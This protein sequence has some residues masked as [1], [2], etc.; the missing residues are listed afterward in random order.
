MNNTTLTKLQFEELK[1]IVKDFC[2]SNLGKNM[3]QKLLPSSNI[4][5]VK[6]RLLETSE[7]K[8]LLESSTVPLQGIV[9]IDNIIIN[10]EKDG[11][12]NPEQLSN[13]SVF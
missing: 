3:I 8:I 7:G 5:T 12:L 6:N 13:V 9:N 4:Q 11:V 10:V 1:N 2:V